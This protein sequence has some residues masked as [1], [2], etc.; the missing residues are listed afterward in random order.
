MANIVDMLAD[1]IVSKLGDVVDYAYRGP[2]SEAMEKVERGSSIAVVTPNDPDD[3]EWRH[4]INDDKLLIGMGLTTSRPFIRRFT[5]TLDRIY[6]RS[7]RDTVYGDFGDLMRDVEL[8]FYGWST[9]VGPDDNGETANA[10]CNKG[11]F[12]SSKESYAGG[13]NEFLAKGKLWLEFQT[14]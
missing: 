3:D 11:V 9:T 13:V 2:K 12:R 6:R 10:A 1:E 4:E 5:V 7:D 8:V 14:D